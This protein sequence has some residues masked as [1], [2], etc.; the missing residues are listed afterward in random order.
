MIDG[1]DFLESQRRPHL[2][3][4]QSEIF[5]DMLTLP[6]SSTSVSN[7]G[8]EVDTV[9]MYD[10]PVKLIAYLRKHAIQALVQ[11]WSTGLEGH[12]A[13]VEIALQAKTGPFR[14][15]IISFDSGVETQRESAARHCPQNPVYYHL[16]FIYTTYINVWIQICHNPQTISSPPKSSPTSACS[17]CLKTVL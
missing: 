8:T 9:P 14:P 3:H 16:I 10:R 15:L 4:R 7:E 13:M 2:W 17:N 1:I 12:D 11:T 5:L 6:Q